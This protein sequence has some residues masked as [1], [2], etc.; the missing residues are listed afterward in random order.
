MD[1]CILPRLS[2]VKDSYSLALLAYSFAIAKH[3]KK[4][5]VMNKLRRKAIVEGNTKQ[6][7]RVHNK[8]HQYQFCEAMQNGY[9]SSRLELDCK[10]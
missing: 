3:P 5:A 6:D 10:V 8:D 9:Y 7:P 4:N 1:K 2:K